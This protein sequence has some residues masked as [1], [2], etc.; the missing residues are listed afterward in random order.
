MLLILDKIEFLQLFM[1]KSI[2]ELMKRNFC[3]V[4]FFSFFLFHI[5][6][7]PA[8]QY[9][10]TSRLILRSLQLAIVY[11]LVIQVLKSGGLIF[12]IDCNGF[13]FLSMTH[14]SGHSKCCSSVWELKL[15]RQQ[16][17]NLLSYQY[18]TLKDS[19]ALLRFIKL[20]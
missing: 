18:P 3:T 10:A 14:I 11:L 9:S 6:Q 17:S 19:V 13:D 2:G 4:F 5:Q 8:L 15:A 12:A 16:H 1:G 20:C 7:T